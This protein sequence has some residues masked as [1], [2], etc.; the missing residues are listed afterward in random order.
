MA[1]HAAEI[2]LTILVMVAGAALEALR[3]HRAQ[4]RRALH[5]HER[6]PRPHGK[7]RRR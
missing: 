1:E 2:I 3:R 7:P 5:P 6:P 4:K